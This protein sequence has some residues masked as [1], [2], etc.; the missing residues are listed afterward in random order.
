M[1]PCLVDLFYTPKHNPKG[2][3]LVFSCHSDYIIGQLEKYQ[4]LLVDKNDDG[5]SKAYR[6]DEVKGVRNVDNHYAKYH[7]GAYG[8]V[9]EF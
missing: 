1:I 4:I 2:A 5:V 3:Q 7:A 6:L 8:G 9:P